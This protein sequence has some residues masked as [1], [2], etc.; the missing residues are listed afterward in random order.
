MTLCHEQFYK[1]PE[2]ELLLYQ[3]I[4]LLLPRTTFCEL[5]VWGRNPLSNKI[6]KQKTTQRGCIPCYYKKQE[7][8]IGKIIS[9]YKTIEKLFL[10][11]H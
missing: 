2:R 9:K 5:S 4:F 3:N 10:R 1:E 6:N 7:K 8:E 11:T